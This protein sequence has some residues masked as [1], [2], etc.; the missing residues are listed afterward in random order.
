MC[1]K[2]GL[3]F[4]LSICLGKVKEF[5]WLG[6]WLDMIVGARRAGLSITKT[7]DLLGFLQPSSGL[8]E[9]GPTERKYAVDGS[10]VE[11]NV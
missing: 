1:G 2:D 10:C 9:N 6:T 11:E 3:E 8:T 7:A 4:K 5:K